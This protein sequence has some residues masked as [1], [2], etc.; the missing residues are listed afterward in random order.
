MKIDNSIKRYQNNNYTTLTNFLRAHNFNNSKNA[1][2]NV[3]LSN[4]NIVNW[5]K[6][7]NSIMHQ[8]NY[9]IQLYRGLDIDLSNKTE[10]INK[11]FTSCTKDIR[12]AK[13]YVKHANNNDRTIIEFNL[14]P[15]IKRYNLKPRNNDDEQEVLIQRNTKFINIKFKKMYNN[16]NVYTADII[17]YYKHKN[18]SNVENKSLDNRLKNLTLNSNNERSNFG[19]N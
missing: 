10:L 17:R 3:R 13:N 1:Y 14:P 11:S 15:H 2:N 5:S 6:A 4:K 18:H 19:N 16:H 7:L 8:T 12:I 9:S